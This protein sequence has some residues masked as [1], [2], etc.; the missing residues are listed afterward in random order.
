[1][2]GVR[3]S[4]SGC[5]KT[6]RHQSK[7]KV[8]TREARTLRR[9]TWRFTCSLIALRVCAAALWASESACSRHIASMRNFESASSR[10]RSIRRQRSSRIAWSWC[11]SLRWHAILLH[12]SSTKWSRCLSRGRVVSARAFQDTDAQGSFTHTHASAALSA[13]LCSF[14]PWGSSPKAASSTTGLN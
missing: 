8:H 3:R 1:M 11:S 10:L 2:Q 13:C 7:V 6:S 12:R 4:I 9:I 5:S 14:C